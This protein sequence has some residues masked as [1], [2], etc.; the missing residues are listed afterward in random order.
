MRELR[1]PECRDTG[2]GLARWAMIIGA[3]GTAG[4]TLFFLLWLSLFF[5]AAG[6]ISIG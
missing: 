2:R 3:I 1:A 4:Q 6:G 5:Q